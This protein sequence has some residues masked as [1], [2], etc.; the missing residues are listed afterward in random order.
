MEKYVYVDGKKYKRGYTTGSCAAAATKAALTM[1]ITGIKIDNVE[2]STPKGINLLIDVFNQKIGKESAQCCFIKDAGDDIDATNNMEIYSK[3][4]IINTEDIPTVCAVKI[5]DYLEISSG[6]GIGIVTKKGLSTEVGRPAINPVPLKMIASEIEK[7]IDEYAIDIDEYLQNRKILVTI[8]APMGE[9]IALDT[10]NSNLGIVGGISIIGTSGIV[11]PMSEEGWKKALS[12]ELSIK[13]E[14]GLEEIIL[15]PGNIGYDIM[16]KVYKKNEK[17]IVKM[18]N[19]IGYMLM[20]SKRL[21][22]KKI[23]IAGHIGKLIKLSAGITNTHS[24]IADARKEIM[25]ANLALL[26]T[27]QSVLKEI[28]ACLTTDAMIT[29]IKENNMEEVFKVISQKASDRA[30]NYM[31]EGKED[32]KVE[33]Y[34]LSM[35]GE[36]LGIGRTNFH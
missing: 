4:E 17:N 23:I 9:K 29:I 21:A 12:A 11:E 19:F 31:R 27:S 8:S 13:A 20:E 24:R 25:I 3:V 15:V 1:M 35:E 5:H 22:F 2:I 36:L 30:W 33:V 18:S 7:I 6:I 14:E 28:D 10:F 32:I 26:G 34:M 16:T